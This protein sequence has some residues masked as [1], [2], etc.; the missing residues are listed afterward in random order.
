MSAATALGFGAVEWGAGPGEAVAGPGDGDRVAEL[1]V[2]AHLKTAGL[3]VQDPE[4]TLGTPRAAAAYV[5]LAVAVGAPHVRYFA[6]GYRGGSVHEL[7]RRHRR[8]LDRL[9]DLAAP[10]GVKVLVETSPDS[11]AATPELAHALVAHQSPKLAGVLYDPG[12]MVIEGAVRPSLAIA[13]LGRHIAHVHVKN[14]AW[15]RTQGRWRWRY[16]NLAAGLLDWP[17]I[18]GALQASGYRGRYA[19]DHLAGRETM[20]LLKSECALMRDLLAGAD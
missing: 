14:I 18:I 8:T 11:L 13:I 2:R 5:R 15:S 7:Q 12:N 6:A 16:A 4:V 17:E 9:I 20:P 3:S 1:C 10:N 19:I